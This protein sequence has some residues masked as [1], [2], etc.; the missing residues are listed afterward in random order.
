[1][2]FDFKEIEFESPMLSCS[3]QQSTDLEDEELSVARYL[4]PIPR[5]HLPDYRRKI[6]KYRFK[7][8]TI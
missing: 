2:V 1:V 8:L 3:E 4:L 7:R 5:E 6:C